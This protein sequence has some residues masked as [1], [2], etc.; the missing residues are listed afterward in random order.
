MVA[1]R[2]T[3]ELAARRLLRLALGL[4]PRDQPIELAGDVQRRDL[5]PLADPAQV[6]LHRPLASLLVGRRAGLE[7]ECLARHR[8]QPFPGLAEA[9]R[10]A[11]PDQRLDPGLER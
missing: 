6:E 3:D 4:L 5:D 10:P 1:V 7:G 8:R 2:V 11:E 9:E